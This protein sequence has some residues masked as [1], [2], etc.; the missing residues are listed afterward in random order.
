MIKKII[1]GGQTGVDRAA[2]DVAMALGIPVGGWCPAGRRALDGPI[3]EKYPLRE[4]VSSGYH[5]RTELNVMDSDGTL[6]LIYESPGAGTSLA[7]N[8]CMEHK[9]PTC[10]IHLAGDFDPALARAK[11]LNWII[12][13]QIERLNIAGPRNSSSSNS[14]YKLAHK[15]LMAILS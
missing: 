14:I 8:H 13:Y 4:T 6:F 15:I 10:F 12:D 5:Q 2:L 1:S 11:V 7:I 3:D 9:K